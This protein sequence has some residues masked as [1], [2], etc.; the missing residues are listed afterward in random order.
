MLHALFGRL[1]FLLTV[2]GQILLFTGPDRLTIGL[3]VSAAGVIL[4]VAESGVAV[5]GGEGR[6]VL[7]QRIFCDHRRLLVAA[8]GDTRVLVRHF[9]SRELSAHFIFVGDVCRVLFFGI[10]RWRLA[11]GWL[12]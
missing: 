9:W 2:A 8:D 4:F 3:I 11:S 5:V 10:C 1:S 7:A 6:G 12:A